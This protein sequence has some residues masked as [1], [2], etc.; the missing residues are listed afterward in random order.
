MPQTDGRSWGARA[1]T[2]EPEH[3]A[4]PPRLDVPP[5]PHVRPR[6]PS[7]PRREAARPRHAGLPAPD[8]ALSLALRA[9]IVLFVLVVL[10]SLLAPI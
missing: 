10:V 4:T 2:P 6:P 9:A 5:R 3:P 1:A 8:R 7:E